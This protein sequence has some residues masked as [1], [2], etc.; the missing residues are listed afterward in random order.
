MPQ[1]T[2]SAALIRLRPLERTNTGAIVEEHIRYWNET[3][4]KEEAAKLAREAKLKQFQRQKSK[5]VNILLTALNP[6]DVAPLF[7]SSFLEHMKQNEDSDA[8][9]ARLAASETGTMKDRVNY[10]R[11]LRQVESLATLTTNVEKKFIDLTG[12]LAENE[13]YNIT[14]KDLFETV[15][16]MTKGFFVVDKNTGDI[17]IISEDGQKVLFDGSAEGL[18]AKFLTSNF[19]PL[20]DFNVTAE[21]IG[22]NLLDTLDGNK[23]KTPNTRIKG[24]RLAESKLA[25]NPLLRENYFEFAKQENY[26]V[27][28]DKTYNEL[29]DVEKS[30]VAIS[31]YDDIVDKT[32]SETFKDTSVKDAI[33]LERLSALRKTRKK[34]AEEGVATISVATTE[35]GDAIELNSVIY[36]RVGLL[37]GDDVFTI[38]GGLSIEEVKGDKKTTTTYTNFARGKKGIVAI[39]KKVI[40]TPLFDEDGDPITDSSGAPKLKEEVIPVVENDKIK[41]GDIATRLTNKEGRPFKN[42]NELDTELKGLNV[43]QKTFSAEQEKLIQDNMDANP[44]YSREEVINILGF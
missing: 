18:Q 9:L 37:Q 38:K 42:L 27:P 3:K 7:H 12:Q 28:K 22:D 33:E 13:G 16:S 31:F 5:D 24:I 15:N 43:E 8:E 2:T 14:D 35:E 44:D 34:E 11:R 25:N 19:S 26:N 20:V 10:Q 23:Q 30:Q 17:R 39:G 41:L 21:D 1:A 36:R 40:K 4:T 32:I 6:E 29:D